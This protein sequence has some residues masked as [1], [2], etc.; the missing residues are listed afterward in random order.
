[1]EADGPDAETR[2]LLVIGDGGGGAANV[3]SGV[4]APFAVMALAA[5]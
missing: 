4:F 3:R 1:M 5:A 2:P